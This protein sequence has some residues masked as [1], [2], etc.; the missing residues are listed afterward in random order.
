MGGEGH[1]LDMIRRLKEGR[2]SANL[3]RART[4][5]RMKR[6]QTKA[7][8]PLPDTTPEEMGRIIRQSKEKKEADDRYFVFG[9]LIIIGVLLACAR[10]IMGYFYSLIVSLTNPS[11]CNWE[12]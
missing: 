1:M 9:T 12:K 6:L 5:E 11:F 7:P 3:R 2:D 10:Y 4:N 8:Y